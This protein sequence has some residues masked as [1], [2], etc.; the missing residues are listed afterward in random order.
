MIQK[1]LSFK[2]NPASK[3]EVE[4]A[5]IIKEIFIRLSEHCWDQMSA[6]YTEDALL[7]SLV[8]EGR[9]LKRDDFLMTLKTKSTESLGR[10]LFFKDILIRISGEQNAICSCVAIFN[11]ANTITKELDIVF[12]LKKQD[13]LWKVK[14]Q[15]YPAIK[16]HV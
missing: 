15:Y 5:N 14:K 8:A 3:E 9:M 12:E 16:Q 7:H 1:R 13:G 2:E 4:V 11:F 10:P 6:L